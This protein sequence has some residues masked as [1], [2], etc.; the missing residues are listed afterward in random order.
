MKEYDLAAI[1][2]L[3]GAQRGILFHSILE[4]HSGAYVAQFSWV[5][6]GP[7]DTSVFARAW[8]AL[9]DRHEILRTA[10]VWE[11]VESMCQVVHR[12][13]P[14]EID[15]QDWADLDEGSHAERL[16]ALLDE[17][18][19]QGFEL[20]RA[21]LMRVYALRL[22]DGVHRILWSHHQLLLDGW[23]T[24]IL[25]RELSLFYDSILNAT[26]PDVAEPAKYGDFLAWHQ[27][28]QAAH[29]KRYWTDLLRDFDEPTRLPIA[30]TAPLA[31]TS[32]FAE[33]RTLLS[34]EATEGLAATARQLKVTVGTVA[35][36]AW[37][38]LLHAYTGAPDVVFG[39]VVAGRPPS[40]PGVESMVGMFI[41]TLPVRSRITDA[42]E[43]GPWLQA[44]Q[45][46]Q[47]E[48]REHEQTPL[49]D[50]QRWA[51]TPRGSALFDSI[52]VFENY[53]NQEQLEFG[54]AG[55]RL[56]DAQEHD[57]THYGLT[58]MV[59]VGEQLHVT[60]LYRTGQFVREAVERMS[61]HYTMLL[62]GIVGHSTRRAREIPL[63]RP[64][65]R[66][67]ITAAARGHRSELQDHLTLDRLFADQVRRTPDAVALTT[68]ADAITYADLDRYST[69]IASRLIELGA[70]SECVVGV[71]LERSP[72]AIAAVLGVLKTGAAY[73]PLDPR[74][75]EGRL[76]FMFEDAGARLL[77]SEEKLARRLPA[78][79]N[80]LLEWIDQQEVDRA[81][82]WQPHGVAT[83][84]GLAHV[85]YTS[86]STGRPKGIATPHLGVINR[87]QWMWAAF[88]FESVET[89]A[90]KTVLGF[91]DSVWEIFGPLLRGVPSVVISDDVVRD[92]RRLAGVLSSA[93]VT[94]LVVVPSLLEAMMALADDL[95]S[96]LDDLKLVICSGEPL[97]TD[98]RL[99]A[100]ERLPG[101]AIV[102]LWGSSE[103]AADS[104][105]FLARRNDRSH[106]EA[107][108]VP[109]G[110][111][112][113]NTEVY[114]LGA[115]G[116]V[117]P[118]GVSGELCI[119]GSGLGRGYIGQP[120]LTASKYVPH[121]FSTEPGAR[122]Y[123]TGDIGRL[124]EDGLLDFV[125]RLDDQVKI[126][127]FRVEL[128]EVETVLRQHDA[129]REAIVVNRPYSGGGARLVAYVVLLEQLSGLTTVLR[130]HLSRL[131]PDFM[132]P[133]AFVALQAF[134]LTPHGKI[135]RKALPDPDAERPDIAV[136]YAAP[137]SGVEVALAGI[138]SSVLGVR[139]VG[140]EDDF[141][142]VGGDSLS[143]L[144]ILAK[145]RAEFGVDIGIR[146][147]FEASTI[148]RLAGLI[149]AR[150][151]AMVA[152]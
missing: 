143:G 140:V 32:A 125:G 129:V 109:L 73:L 38:L 48:A 43:I 27:Q 84:Q 100:L 82:D 92:A 63:V 17:D 77:I 41:N 60:I 152:E 130:D 31:Q 101:A 9:I 46:A 18:R 20:N 7:F 36:G 6:E 96:A 110:K 120:A 14:F 5:L 3:T 148:A 78:A 74:Y 114:V 35:L 19:E 81:S 68:D 151:A 145:T 33:V 87:L 62:E 124:T 39:N 1:Y 69:A 150:R 90:Q 58:A 128:G 123:R 115:G 45:S 49:V 106:S 136:E 30:L 61:E 13:V 112:I 119:A 52:F 42:E 138:W 118:I 93:K 146:E 132:I 135:D 16:K 37:A 131:L 72:A 149:E 89:C 57:R 88:P 142:E 121:P 144:R 15:L 28:S 94:R 104:T 50:I 116:D 85:L 127:G 98:L 137:K 97:P 66:A 147:L 76:A 107:P 111:P 11:R 51:S 99:R 24:P 79:S 70:E 54:P 23:S 34:R 103:N 10:F 4:P 80:L 55:L 25:H 83:P 126:R 113:S 56:T 86:G 53:P 40:F 29:S 117:A 67:R 59:Y 26:P 108:Y 133:A 102:N 122:M 44:L 141:F 65:E 139:A 134:P 21:P 91:V 105:Y 2:P 47:V 12:T 64:A 8:R 75:P 71:M 22:R 95:L